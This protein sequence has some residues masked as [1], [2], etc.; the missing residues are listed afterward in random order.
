MEASQSQRR[1]L[2]WET[3]LTVSIWPQI[4][5]LVGRLIAKGPFDWDGAHSQTTSP[6]ASSTR[7]K[8]SR[9]WL[10]RTFSVM[11]EFDDKNDVL[12]FWEVSEAGM[13]H[14]RHHHPL[15][16]RI[17]AVWEGLLKRLRN[18]MARTTYSCCFTFRTRLHD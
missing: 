13:K 17:G 6:E 16:R 15:R 14:W 7:V 2:G 1:R 18:Y 4:F 3:R 8:T 10:S 11:K 12:L 9:G 5:E